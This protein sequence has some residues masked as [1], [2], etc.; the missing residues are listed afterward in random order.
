MKIEGN[1]KCDACPQVLASVAFRY[2]VF[3]CYFSILPLFCG[4]LAIPLVF[5]IPLLFRECFHGCSVFCRSGVPGFIVCLFYVVFQ[6]LKVLLLNICKRQPP[7]LL[8][9]FFLFGFS[10]TNIHDSQ[11]SRGRGRVS[12]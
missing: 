11:D 2:P 1:E 7:D 9:L 6:L 3:R 4:I 8:F 12:I 10:F 5:R